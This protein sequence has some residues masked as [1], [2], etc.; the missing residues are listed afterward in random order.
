MLRAGVL[1]IALIALLTH[2]VYARVIYPPAASISTGDITTTHIRNETITGADISPTATT[3]LGRLGLG[4]TT[5]WHSATLA[6]EQN[7][8][9][10]LFTAGDTGTST[11][12]LYIDA[13]GR[14]GVRTS[15]STAQFH[16]AG[17]LYSTGSSTL[18]ST[19][20]VGGATRL[21][22]TLSVDGASTLA[23]IVTGNITGSSTIGTIF[24]VGGNTFLHGTLKVNGA[25]TLNE[26]SY[27]WPS[28][29]GTS[30][31]SLQTDGAGTLSWAGSSAFVF[32]AASTTKLS[33][34]NNTSENTIFGY[35]LDASAMGTNGE[36]SCNFFGD[37]GAGA[38]DTTFKFYFG[39][40]LVHTAT[41]TDD[42]LWRLHVR[43]T[44]RNSASAQ[45]STMYGLI[46][47]VNQKLDTTKTVNTAVAT[48]VK[49]SLTKTS[50]ADPDIFFIDHAICEI[51]QRS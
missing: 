38:N 19:L 23:S 29:D 33:G 24:N 2:F 18:S 30:G 46:N 17:S 15:T 49:V 6:I 34:Q 28:A 40:T 20:N 39:G 32:S 14:V 36:L 37:R 8:V 5:P 27:T 22:S 10:P 26:V 3:T 25:T 31:Q 50:T 41:L 42:G 9:N 51:L 13:K 48:D 45:Y 11:P 7:G 1:A 44:N 12:W 4:T 35:T 21:H 43:V 47:N 16:V